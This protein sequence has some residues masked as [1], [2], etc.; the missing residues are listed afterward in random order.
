MR[1]PRARSTSRPLHLAVPVAIVGLLL[2]WMT[3]QADVVGA[4]RVAESR[5]AGQRPPAGNQSPSQPGNQ[6]AAGPRNASPAAPA[7]QTPPAPPPPSGAP[8][9]VSPSIVLHV[10]QKLLASGLPVPTVS[11]AWGD[12][13]SAALS[14]YQRKH[15]LDPG[16]DLDELT[17]VALG[18]PEVLRGEQPAAA[19]TPVSAQ[20]AATGGAPL[21]I[22]PRLTRLLQNRLTE[23]GFPTDNVFGVWL[24]GSATAAQNFQKARNLEVTSTLDLSLLHVLGLTASFADPKPG[25]WPTDG[26][27]QILSEKAETFTGAPV[28]LGP[29]GIRQIQAALRQRGHKDLVSDGKWSEELGTRL[30]AFQESQKLEP[31]GS[32]NLRTLRALGFGQPLVDLDLAAT[33]QTLK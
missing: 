23:G 8:I 14:E 30:K 27:A 32:V 3:F 7:N 10:Q 28:Y 22:S 4:G 5:Q 19:T 13:S 25:K 29:G 17:L 31:T 24:P 15:G 2:T 11:G 20:A 12:L 26:V 18:M 9:Y 6:S 33:A 1:A 21:H 16:G